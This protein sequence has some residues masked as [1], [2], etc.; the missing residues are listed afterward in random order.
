MRKL[1]A[2]LLAVA[3]LAGGTVYG[4]V[5]LAGKKPPPPSV[6]LTAISTQETA[7]SLPIVVRG[8]R[9]TGVLR[10]VFVSANAKK[11]YALVRHGY[12][13]APNGSF[14][15]VW[16]PS[17]PPGA[18]RI[19]VRTTHGVSTPIGVRIHPQRYFR[20]GQVCAPLWRNY[21]IKGARGRW[22]TCTRL[23]ARYRWMAPKAPPKPVPLPAAPATTLPAQP[24]QP[25]TVQPPTVIIVIQTAPPA[26]APSPTRPTT[27][28]ARVPTVLRVVPAS[29]P[30]SGG[31]PVT[32]AGSHLEQGIVRFGTRPAA[33]TCGEFRCTVTSPAGPPGTVDVTVSTPGGTSARSRADEFTY[34]APP[35]PPPVSTTMS[36]QQRDVSGGSMGGET[37]NIVVVLHPSD[38]RVRYDAGQLTIGCAV[39]R[40]GQPIWSTT[41]GKPTVVTVEGHAPGAFASPVVVLSISHSNLSC[42][43]PGA[44]GYVL[45]VRYTG[46]MTG[47]GA[48]FAPDTW[49]AVPVVAEGPNASQTNVQS[50]TNTGGCPNTPPVTVSTALTMVENAAP[51]VSGQTS[52]GTACTASTPCEE[53][54]GT[55]TPSNG[56]VGPYP[57]GT[58]VTLR[59]AYGPGTHGIEVEQAP[60]SADRTYTVR[61]LIDH[62]SPAAAGVADTSVRY[63]GGTSTF[64]GYSIEWSAAQL[65]Q[66]GTNP[67]GTTTTTT[68]VATTTSSTTTSST[69]TT[70]S[71]STTTSVPPETSTSS[72]TTPAPPS[73]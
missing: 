6:R 23:A 56:L 46:G 60:V 30:T 62:C 38:A 7:A 43:V 32:I 63:A 11:G 67:T 15:K 22:I 27:P 61:G 57:S 13:V 1:F 58:T 33:G 54:T 26:P 52:S 3:L 18:Y 20:A 25:V 9:L 34:V 68:T 42:T 72:T 10:V 40:A 39:V 69:P 29:G 4:S 49:C 73:T 64:E 31:T 5:A 37:K 71:S 48:R 21:S 53:W 66:S 17:I 24:A 28:P 8:T 70:S 44:S 47:S 36:L 19:Q 41:S 65:E 50:E 16:T 59:C 2:A 51:I 45:Y 55:L 35:P 12:A 14:I